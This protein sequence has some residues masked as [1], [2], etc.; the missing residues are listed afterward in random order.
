MSVRVNGKYKNI[1]DL[2]VR[3]NIYKNLESFNK[4]EILRQRELEIIDFQK[5]IEL[6]SDEE[7]FKKAHIRFQKWLKEDLDRELLF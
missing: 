2:E 6:I 3:M 1:L 4:S 7:Q 5:E